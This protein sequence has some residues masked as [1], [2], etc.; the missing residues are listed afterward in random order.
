MPVAAQKSRRTF[1][2]MAAA[3][4]IVAIALVAALG[5]HGNNPRVVDIP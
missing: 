4:L 2:R 1:L 3:G 5:C